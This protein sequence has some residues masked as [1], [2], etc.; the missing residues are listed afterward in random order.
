MNKTNAKAFMDAVV[1][2]CGSSGIERVV[3]V[4]EGRLVVMCLDYYLLLDV[5]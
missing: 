3:G 1:D 4:I 2:Y 5:G